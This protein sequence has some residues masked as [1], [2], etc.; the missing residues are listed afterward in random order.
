MTEPVVATLRPGAPKRRRLRASLGAIGLAVVLLGAGCGE[1]AVSDGVAPD[2]DGA[3]PQDPQPQDNEQ[4]AP[5]ADEAELSGD[6]APDLGED[7]FDE[8]TSE[9]D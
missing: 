1:D 7:G 2:A 3:P 9:Q 4:E 5:N 8:N 6:E